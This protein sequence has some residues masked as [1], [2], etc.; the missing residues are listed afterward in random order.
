M[1]QVIRR[2]VFIIAIITLFSCALSAQNIQ[3]HYDL[4][5]ALYNSLSGRP[6]ITTTVEM[7]KPDRWGSTFF[8]IDM[9]YASEG[10][11]AAYWEVAREL[12]FWKGDISA[13]IEY[14]G[15]MPYIRNA[16]LAGATY[17]YNNKD[18]TRGFSFSTMYK[19]IQKLESP[20]QF[21]LTAVWRVEFAAGKLFF[22]GFADWWREPNYYGDYIFLAEP[23]FW[24]RLN[25]FKGVDDN[26]NLSIGSETEL[27]RN[28]AGRDGFYA[29]PTL[30][31]RWDF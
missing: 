29:I 31:V 12:K 19:H 5:H 2:K 8:F 4:G 25:R 18:F 21:Q 7:F 16:Y 1:I 28:F 22:T 9:D 3:L 27:S 26:F 14:N 6:K 11:M 17:T 23:Q 13:H 24:M 20:H 30:A 10:V 15:G